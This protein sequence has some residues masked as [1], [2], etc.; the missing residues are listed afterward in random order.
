MKSAASPRRAIVAY[1]TKLAIQGIQARSGAKRPVRRRCKKKPASPSTRATA[2]SALRPQWDAL[3]R[4]TDRLY[5]EIS[6]GVK[7]EPVAA[8]PYA[9]ADQMAREVQETG[10]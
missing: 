9:S 3:A 7:T 10:V 5:E 6:R 2:V 1:Q 4:E 8:Q